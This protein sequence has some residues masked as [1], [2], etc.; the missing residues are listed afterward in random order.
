MSRVA[1]ALML[2]LVC[3]AGLPARAM[4]QAPPPVP[5]CEEDRQMLRIFSAAV[6]ASRTRSEIEAA[7]EIARLNRE[8]AELRRQIEAARKMEKPGG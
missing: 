2:V 4:A 1:V 5:A 7:G 6:T 3:R 8:N